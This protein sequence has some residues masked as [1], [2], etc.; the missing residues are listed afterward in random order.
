M[1]RPRVA[2]PRINHLTEARCMNPPNEKRQAAE[3]AIRYVEDGAIVGVGTGST[4][5]FFIDAL[6]DLR[7]RI[8]GAVSSSEQSTAHLKRLGIPVLDLN[9]AGPLTIYVD[10]ADECDPHKRLIKGGGA[11]LT[12]E[13][14]VAQASEK[15]VCIIDSS[16]C[17]N[18]LGRFPLP[19]EVIPMARSL[20]G[21]EIVKLGGNPVWRD[22]VVTDNGNWIIDVHGW[23]IADPVGLES[24]LNQLPGI[25]SVGLFARRPADVVLVGDREL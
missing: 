22:G 7:D 20:I 15:F 12:R 11:A 17:V 14:I 8:Q 6:A 10:G 18:L 13:K 23:Q 16:K 2:P 19:I 21:R 1:T 5:S 24:E 4:V 9:S 3:A 25:V